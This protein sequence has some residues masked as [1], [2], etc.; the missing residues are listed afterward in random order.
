MSCL[1]F[2]APTSTKTIPCMASE[3]FSGIGI[4]HTWLKASTFNRFHEGLAKS[5]IERSIQPLQ[6]FLSLPSKA[7]PSWRNLQRFFAV[8]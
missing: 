2:L 6:T 7:E 1:G 4:A 3:I 5:A 8:P